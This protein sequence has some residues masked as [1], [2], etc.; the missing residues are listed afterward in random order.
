MKPI[1]ITIW[2]TIIGTGLTILL[3]KIGLERIKA[4]YHGYKHAWLKRQLQN[5]TTNKHAAEAAER[6]V[7][8]RKPEK[9]CTCHTGGDDIQRGF[10]AVHDAEM[11]RQAAESDKAW[12]EWAGSWYKQAKQRGLYDMVAA[13]GYDWGSGTGVHLDPYDC[14]NKENQVKNSSD[15]GNVVSLSWYRSDK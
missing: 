12:Y 11:N 3:T 1:L 6:A 13:T 7:Q 14:L 8:Q 15:P 4:N 10:C 9:A 2:L 5:M